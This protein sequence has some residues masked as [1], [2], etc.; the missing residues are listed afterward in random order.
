LG[1]A[2]KVDVVVP[3]NIVVETTR[4]QVKVKEQHEYPSGGGAEAEM[5]YPTRPASKESTSASSIQE[6][7][8]I[9]EIASVQEEDTRSSSAHDSSASSSV[10]DGGEDDSKQI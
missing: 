5:K 1:P 6:V 9:Q 4:H 10:R 7:A 8:S 2:A 3:D